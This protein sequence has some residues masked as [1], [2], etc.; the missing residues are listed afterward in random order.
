MKPSPIYVLAGLICI[1]LHS[2]AQPT[3]SESVRTG[4]ILNRLQQQNGLSTG[5][6][7]LPSSSA[8]EH[9]VEGDPYWD[10]H[11]S[12][13][14]IQFYEKDRWATGYTMRYN[15]RRNDFELFFSKDIRVVEGNQIRHM[16]FADSLSGK[17]RFLIN[18]KE[19][20][21]H[22]VQMIGFFEV[23]VD[24]N[25]ALLKHIRLEILKPDF[26]PALNVGSKN[27]RILKKESYF[28]NVGKDVYR[29]KSKKSVDML[30]G[31]KEAEMNQFIK[32]E[33]IR[34]NRES[35]LIKLFSHFSTAY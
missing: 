8:T 6:L 10:P 20:K 30:F 4:N 25:T 26:S 27:T 2:L 9:E 18:A 33:A 24:G 35:D 14:A 1:T 11:W 15:I 34:F 5:D 3:V 23:L 13:G 16:V 29:I 32:K 12:K 17:T 19:Y 31:D 7:I 21:E 28:F 22:D